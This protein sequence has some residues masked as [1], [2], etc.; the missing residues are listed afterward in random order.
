MSHVSLTITDDDEPAVPETPV[1]TLVLTPA[2][3]GEN[4]GVGRVTATASPAS[5]EAFT[6][7]VS[8]VGG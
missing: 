7:T 5:A 8:A 1:V 4:G 3:I 2:S 6:V